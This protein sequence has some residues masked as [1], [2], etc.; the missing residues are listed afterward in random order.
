MIRTMYFA[1][2]FAGAAS[3]V[4]I[5]GCGGGSNATPPAISV[6]GMPS[7]AAVQPGAAAQFS[8]T[9]TNDSGNKGVAWTVSCSTAPCGTV[10]PAATA[11]GVATTYT[12]PPTAPASALTVTITATSVTNAS[13]TASAVVTVPAAAAVSVSGAPSTATVQPGAT[14]QFTAT[15]SND[16]ANKGVA[17]T[18]SCST[19]PC[20]TVSPATTA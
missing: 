2:W 13:A 6:A 19:A 7:T 15:V 5:A 4:L 11:S 18:V 17:W 1:L 9:V 3:A 12:A 20:G 10:S 14:A 16:T 8:A